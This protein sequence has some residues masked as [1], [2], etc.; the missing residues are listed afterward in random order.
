[1]KS[2][3]IV[4]QA[5]VVSN[6][7][8]AKKIFWLKL[9]STYL[10]ERTEPGQF[11]NIL[12]SGNL[13]PLWRRPFSVARITG[14]IIEIIYKVIGRGTRFM[15]TLKVDDTANLLGP[16]GNSFNVQNTDNR[17]PMLIGGGLG[18]APLIIL[19]DAL[20][21][22]GID[23]VLFMGTPTQSE[24]YYKKDNKAGLLL[25]SDDGSLG[26]HGFVTDLLSNYLAENATSNQ[27]VAYSCGP[28]PMMAKVAAI[29]RK[30]NIPLQLSI[31]R[32]MAC[33]IG[34]CQGCV[35]EQVPPQRKYA[36]VC[37]DGPIFDAKTLQFTQDDHGES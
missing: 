5:P 26:Y 28:E 25:S 36:L 23:P 10:A 11:V 34:F 7:E 19:R 9:R 12:A 27:Y 24:H 21:N 4:E 3:A 35:I 22:S 30:H 13:N 29:C 37:K 33:G 18:F 8:V 16:L 6:E 32:E 15:S 20:V 1:L 31:E 17:I 2:D 14:N